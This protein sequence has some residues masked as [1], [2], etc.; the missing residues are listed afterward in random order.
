MLEQF[1]CPLHCGISS[2]MLMPD[3]LPIWI[4]NGDDLV[5]NI[6]KVLKFSYSELETS[7]AF[8]RHGAR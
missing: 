7:L 4:T 6:E 2:Q 1:W 3:L 8:S 5:D